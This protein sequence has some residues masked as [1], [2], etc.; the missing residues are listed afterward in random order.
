MSIDTKIKKLIE[1]TFV[2]PEGS[3]TAAAYKTLTPEQ[4][5]NF[6]ADNF[7]TRKGL[8]GAAGALGHG[9]LLGGLIG[10]GTAL[11]NEFAGTN[12]DPLMSGVMTAGATGLLS[13]PGSYIDAKDNAQYLQ[14]NIRNT[15]KTKGGIDNLAKQY[16]D[17][18]RKNKEV[19]F[20]QE[21]RDETRKE[22]M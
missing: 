18:F 20:G 9:A 17:T 6:M 19:Q 14:D 10:G 3:D 1:E 5:K 2:I 8:G 12:F 7:A 21:L 4:Q 22:M 15:Q 13:T 11:A 16:D